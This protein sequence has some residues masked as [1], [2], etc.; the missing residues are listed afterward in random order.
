MI[1][2]IFDRLKVISL[3]S[4][5]IK[6]GH[7]YYLCK[8]SCGKETKTRGDVLRSGNARSCGCISA[9]NGAFFLKKYATSSRHKGKNNPA[10]KGKNATYPAFHSWLDRHYKKYICEHCGDLQKKLDWALKK[11]F[12]HDHDRN[13][14]LIL[15][16]SCH[17][18]Y[19]KIKHETRSKHNP[20]NQK[21][22]KAE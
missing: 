17:I 9:E 21:I 13:N 10:W 20:D 19:D 3:F 12:E 22:P 2:R 16:R 5:D 6:H 4:T 18:K 14:Y 7:T 1:G 15:C 8:C 11:G